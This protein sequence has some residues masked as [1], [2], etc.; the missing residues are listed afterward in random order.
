MWDILLRKADTTEM[1]GP[2]SSNATHV[3]FR[4]E[5][6]SRL[7]HVDHCLSYLRE[8]IM[9]SGDTSLEETI[10]TTDGFVQVNMNQLHTCRSWD[11]IWN[12]TEEH[13]TKPRSWIQ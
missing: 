4:K 6:N 2:Y 11:Y 13:G 7:Q 1:I 8:A 5:A 9:C 3:D 10:L 12:Y